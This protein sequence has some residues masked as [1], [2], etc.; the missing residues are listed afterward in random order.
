MI[1]ASQST[2]AAVAQGQARSSRLA[3]SGELEQTCAGDEPCSRETGGRTAT[4]VCGRGRHSVLPQRG[5]ALVSLQHLPATTHA[6]QLHG[7]P[8][9]E[10]GSPLPVP[11]KPGRFP[12]S[13]ASRC[14]DWPRL[15]R[16]HPVK[17]PSG[18]WPRSGIPPFPVLPEGMAPCPQEAGAFRGTGLRPCGPLPLFLGDTVRCPDFHEN[19]PTLRQSHRIV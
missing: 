3:S 14:P 16:G 4:A 11:P 19:E 13:E 2:R 17:R 12:V 9:Q 5:E 7:R 1:L 10:Q 18:R 6:M 15:A 8:A